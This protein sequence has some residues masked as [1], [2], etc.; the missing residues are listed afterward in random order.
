MQEY[1]LNDRFYCLLFLTCHMEFVLSH[2]CKI[3]FL[4]R[5]NLTDV[6]LFQIRDATKQFRRFYLFI[7]G[8]TVEILQLRFLWVSLFYA[9]LH[10]SASTHHLFRFHCVYAKT[11]GN[12]T[13]SK[14]AEDKQ[15]SRTTKKFAH[16]F[17]QRE[18]QSNNQMFC[19]CSEKKIFESYRA[20]LR[21]CF[22]D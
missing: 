22:G 16:I 21:C 3:S 1:T 8:Q 15:N 7:V 2:Y 9:E 17:L 13:D 10:Y 18:N 5:K 19:Y 12:G 6:C 20:F 4:H 14:I 11:F